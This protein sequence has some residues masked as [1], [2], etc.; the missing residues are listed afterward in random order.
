MKSWSKKSALACATASLLLAGGARA[1]QTPA[2]RPAIVLPD[3]RDAPTWQKWTSE[4]GWQLIAPE[5]DAHLDAD[6][7]ALALS[8]AV[9]NAVKANTAD[10]AHVY[11]AARGEDAALVFYIV[12]RVPDLWAAGLAL[13]G[14]PKP[15]IA[16]GL[17]FA[18]NFTNTPVYWVSS[19]PGDS[20]LASRLK[21]AGLNI[22][23]RDAKDISIAKCFGDLLERARAENPATADCETNTAKF[24]RCFW[25]EPDKFDSGERYEALPSTRVRDGSGAGLD[26]GGFGYRLSDP[27]PGVL[28]SYLPKE[29]IGPLKIG[30]RVIELDGQPIAD[31]RD[32]D[33]RL[34]KVTAERP[35]VALIARGKE[36]MRLETRIVLPRLDAII[37]ARVQ[38]K[39][40][41][42]SKTLRIASRSISEMR[43]NIP[44]QWAPSDLYWDGLPLQHLEKPG[45][46]L[47]S[48]G[49]ELLNASPCSE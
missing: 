22:E 32:F 45:C 46:Y 31:A 42:E 28:I 43:L 15:A 17:L 38:G 41:A 48:I 16:S 8:D 13:G 24:A 18:A 5:L 14:S 23:W 9:R 4:L 44:A 20:D 6:A 3:P 19:V 33:A 36:R 39:Y 30:D 34:N 35:A 49:K 27:G 21:S 12:S 7:R 29:Y 2:P 37:T 47:L 40:D 1:Q 26:L 11:L 25:I 10:P